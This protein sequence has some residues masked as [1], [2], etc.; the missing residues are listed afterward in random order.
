MATTMRMAGDK[1][2]KGGK[3][4]TMVTKMASKWTVTAMKRAMVTARRVAGK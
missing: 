4:M 3:A 1:E 2:G